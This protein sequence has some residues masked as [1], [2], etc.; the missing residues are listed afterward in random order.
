MDIVL[1]GRTVLADEAMSIGL[2]TRLVDTREELV[3]C[4]LELAATMAEYPQPAMHVTKFA[5]TSFWER[6][7]Y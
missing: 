2:I 3:P 1:S 7:C 5:G 6:G 4:A